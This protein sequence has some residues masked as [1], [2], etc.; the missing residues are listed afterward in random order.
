MY[1]LSKCGHTSQKLAKPALELLLLQENRA[2]FKKS[3]L[4]PVYIIT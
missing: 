2:V 1:Y 4:L 3:T